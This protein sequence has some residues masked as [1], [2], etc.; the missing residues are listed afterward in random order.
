[1]Y[2]FLFHFYLF[3][4]FIIFIYLFLFSFGG[5]GSE[6]DV[7]STIVIADMGPLLLTRINFNPS[8]HK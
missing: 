8:M 7:Y 1:M 5:G 2:N 3:Y 6:F 4:L